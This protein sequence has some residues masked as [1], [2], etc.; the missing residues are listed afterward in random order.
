MDTGEGREKNGTGMDSMENPDSRAAEN[1][2]KDGEDSVIH[3]KKMS[4]KRRKEVKESLY[5]GLSSVIDYFKVWKMRLPC[6]TGG[7]IHRPVKPQLILLPLEKET[8]NFSDKFRDL[9]EKYITLFRAESQGVQDLCDEG[10]ALAR[11]A[12]SFARNERNSLG[13]I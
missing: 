12:D 10:L 11:K 4:G 13:R 1:S 3:L 2:V 8:Q 6:A 7:S 5:N 9:G